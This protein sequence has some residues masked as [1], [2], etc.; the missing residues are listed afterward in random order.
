MKVTPLLKQAVDFKTP[1][2]VRIKIQAPSSSELELL[3]EKGAGTRRSGFAEGPS[4]SFKAGKVVHWHTLMRRK[5]HNDRFV[6]VPGKIELARARSLGVDAERDSFIAL[7]AISTLFRAFSKAN[8]RSIKS[9]VV[10]KSCR[11]TPAAAATVAAER[12]G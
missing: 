4:S 12:K 9:D 6:C 10:P 2:S 8:W 7:L 1:K 5:H 3:H 11:V